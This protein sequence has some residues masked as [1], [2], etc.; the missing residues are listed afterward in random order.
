MTATGRGV[1]GVWHDVVAGQEQDFDNWYNREHHA[2][3]VAVPGFLRARRYLNLGCGR[4]IFSRYDVR[5]VKVMGSPT[6]LAALNNPTPWSQRMFPGYRNTLR[7]CF[8]IILRHGDVE[9]GFVA[10]L[11]YSAAADVQA[12]LEG[13]GP[14]LAETFG[15]LGVEVWRAD[16]GIT[17]QPTMEKAL[18]AAP[19]TFPA[20]VL[21]IDAGS[22]EVARAALAA[23]PVRDVA[24]AAEVDVL[25]LVYQK[26]AASV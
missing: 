13:I 18:R 6:Y 17:L 1:L 14:A 20:L 25:Q 21:L 2:E 8:D 7:A 24:G 10:C 26:L 9:G 15:V 4:R 11:R 16:T 22:F 19:D 3:R 5:D 12:Q 23:P